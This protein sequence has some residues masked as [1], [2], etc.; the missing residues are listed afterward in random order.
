MNP[1]GIY[2]I[3][4]LLCLSVG[5]SSAPAHAHESEKARQIVGAMIDRNDGRTVYNQVQ[6][7]TCAYVNKNGKRTCSS[8]PVKKRI[9]TISIDVGKNLEDTI[10]LGII[11]DPPSEKNMAFLQ[12]DYDQEGRESDQWLYFPALKK[13]KRIVSQN[14][15]SPRT[16]SVFGSEIAYEDVEKMHLSSYSYTYD[17][18]EEVDKRLCDKITASPTVKHAPKTSY[19]KEVLWIDRETKI[20]LKRE[21]YNKGGVLVKTFYCKNLAEI[22]GAWIYKARIVVN[23]KTRHMTLEKMTASAVNMPVDEELVGLRA[24]KDVSFRESNLRNI[25]KLAR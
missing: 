12:K 11:N 13:L 21:L 24:L 5:P 4:T 22:N 25:R 7:I 8:R 14:E 20:P 6:L 17:G 9:E 18:T 10:S 23:H 16:G 1:K 2:F 15:N 19:S 3:L